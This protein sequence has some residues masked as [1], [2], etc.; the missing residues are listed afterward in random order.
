[1]DVDRL[2][3][4]LWSW[5][6]AAVTAHP[7]YSG[8]VFASAAGVA[9]TVFA[10]A[11]GAT[12]VGAAVAGTFFGLVFLGGWLLGVLVFAP[13]VEDQVDIGPNQAETA[14][15]VATASWL[16]GSGGGVAS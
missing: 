3:L 12:F 8:A 2:L 7:V 14:A 13:R 15:E 11:V 10:Y 4:R 9:I 1:L 16:D 5:H 6:V